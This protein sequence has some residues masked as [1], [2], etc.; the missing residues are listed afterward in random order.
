[1]IDPATGQDVASADPNQ[2]ERWLTNLHRSLFLGDGGRIAMA[3]GAAA[4]LVLSLSGAALVA[5]RMG[6]WRHWF[7]PLRGSLA[8]R[9]HVEI[10]RIAVFGLIL[11]STTALWMTGVHLRSSARRRRHASRPR[12]GQR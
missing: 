11:S 2:L 7:A 8:G 5:R 3:A 6:G 12:R 10:A 1:M 9:L 4:M